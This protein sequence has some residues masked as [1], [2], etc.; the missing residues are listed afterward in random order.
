MGLSKPSEIEFRTY[1][2][3]SGVA[4]QLN[5]PAGDVDAIYSWYLKNTLADMTKKDTKQVFLKNLGMFKLK[6]KEATYSLG[7]AVYGLTDSLN[8]YF[9]RGTQEQF[10]Q[11]HISLYY[12]KTRAVKITEGIKTLRIRLNDLKQSGLINE[13]SLVNYLTRLDQ[14]ENQLNQ[15]YESIQRIPELEQKRTTERGQDITWTDEQSSSPF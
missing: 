13:L 8:N 5:I 14:I 11:G 7:R 4:K 9:T 10:K 2:L 6:P 3:Y 1:G 15:L 12:L